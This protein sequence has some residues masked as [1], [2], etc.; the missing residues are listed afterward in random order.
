MFVGEV[1]SL[2]NR[3]KQLR[4]KYGK[5]RKKILMSTSASGGGE[6]N[7]DDETSGWRY[8]SALRFLEPHMGMHERAEHS[9][10]V[11]FRIDLK[12]I[13]S[14]LY[15]SMTKISH[16]NSFKRLVTFVSRD[17]YDDSC[18]SVIRNAYTILRT[19]TIETSNIEDKFGRRW[20]TILNMMVR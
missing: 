1:R 8:Y 17:I 11:C 14:S 3:W 12:L 19:R 10:R 7:N 5:E 13:L 2:Y 16:S 20:L 4:D 15:R 6:G 18:R 9:H